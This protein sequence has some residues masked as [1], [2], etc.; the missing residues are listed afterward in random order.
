ML[1][2]TVLDHVKQG[3]EPLK[4]G[5]LDVA[6]LH[7]QTLR[8]LLVLGLDELHGWRFSRLNMMIV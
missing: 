3:V 1:L 7:R 5:Q 8:N 2:A 4:I 6:T